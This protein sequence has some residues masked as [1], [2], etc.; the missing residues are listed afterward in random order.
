LQSCACQSTCL[1]MVRQRRARVFVSLSGVHIAVSRASSP[2]V[3]PQ[4]GKSGHQREGIRVEDLGSGAPPPSIFGSAS[5]LVVACQHTR[6][7]RENAT[8]K[9]S[10]STGYAWLER[11]AGEGGAVSELYP[12]RRGGQHKIGT[13]W[14][15]P[16]ECPQGLIPLPPTS[17]LPCLV[18]TTRRPCAAL[19]QKGGDDDAIPCRRRRE[20]DGVCESSTR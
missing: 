18:P 20:A 7:T 15:G 19:H 12:A 1:G 11:V 6:P 8:S 10:C 5:L 13:F 4:P 16:W 17:F 14:I 9:G 3:S 2:A